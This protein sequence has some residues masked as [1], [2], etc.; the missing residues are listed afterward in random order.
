VT[1]KRPKSPRAR[2]RKSA[3]ARKPAKTRKD[4]ATKATGT[5]VHIGLNAVNPAN[6][7]GWSGPLAACE[8]DARDM[9]AIAKTQGITSTVL[10]TK[11]AT[12]AKALAA[13]RAAAK[14]L[15]SG[16]LFVLSYSGHGG[17]VDDVSGEEDD[18][19]DETW[20]LY[21]GQLIDD[22]LYLEL[23][24]FAKGVRV[25]VLS[26]SCHSGTVTRAL[27]PATATPGQ[28][29]KL[30]PPDIAKRVYADHKDFYDQLQRDVMRASK[31]AASLD[32][33]AALAHVAVSSRLTNVAAK[34]K[35]AVILISGCQDNQTSM[36]GQN[37]GAF[38]EQLLSVW[39]KGAYR[40]NYAK[41]HARIKAQL[42]STQTPNLFQLGP[43]VTFAQEQPFS[44]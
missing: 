34:A 8:A 18:K 29:P 26:D 24:R 38:T 35:A 14:Q 32:P 17:Q 28:R 41:F 37:N 7:S 19:L 40:G 10:L 31:S 16:D 42:P 9:A 11:D 21:D 6:Y 20:C 39:N 3:A 43:T 27:P 15:K 23:S 12:R 44:V 13:I 4:A 33:D 1:K 5:S 30:M 22:E 25:L 36:D 2:G